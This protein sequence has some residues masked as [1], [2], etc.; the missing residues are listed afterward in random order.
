MLEIC[1]LSTLQE[2]YFRGYRASVLFEGVD[3]YVGD[4]EQ[5]RTLF[6]TLFPFWGQALD[7][8]ALTQ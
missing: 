1:V 8:Q 5:K 6:A 3:T 7:W 4:Q 2:L